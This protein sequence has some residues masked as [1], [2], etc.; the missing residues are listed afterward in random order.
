MISF[1]NFTHKILPYLLLILLIQIIVF[2]QTHSFYE[3][4]IK[5]AVPLGF[6]FVIVIPLYALLRLKKQQLKM[7]ES[8]LKLLEKFK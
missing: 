5:L 8:L 1:T 2:L 7:N 6:V 3:L 4:L